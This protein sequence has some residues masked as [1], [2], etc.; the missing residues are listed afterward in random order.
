[1]IID[2]HV[3]FWDLNLFSYAWISPQSTV[4]YRTYRPEDIWPHLQTSCV[5]GAVFVQANDLVEES[6]WV[7]GL[8]EEFSWLLGVV[9]WVDLA[10]PDIESTLDRLGGHPRY[11]G[12]RA[13]ASGVDW[14][15]GYSVQR[16]LRALAER[17]LSLDVLTSP[18][19]LVRLPMILRKHPHLQI[20]VDHLAGAPIASGQLRQWQ[21]DFR[22]VASEPNAVAKVSGMLTAAICGDGT[23][24]DIEPFLQ[25]ALDCFG[26]QRL[27][28]GGDWPVSLLAAS[29]ANTVTATQRALQGV[30]AADAEYI[31]YKTAQRVYRLDLN[32]LP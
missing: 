18:T 2:S 5:A 10:A 6:D 14:L 30:C 28:F 32:Q 17:G 27:M 21:Q 31:W 19:E 22:E 4:L 1:M 23:F 26:P 11:K 13:G 7:L 12:V 25:T 3:H 16:G 20:I 29:Y 24:A 8:T 9:G 15:E